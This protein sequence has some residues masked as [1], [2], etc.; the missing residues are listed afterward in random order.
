MAVSPDDDGHGSVG[1]VVDVTL[2]PR[3]LQVNLVW[4]GK[5]RGRGVIGM[6]E[7]EIGLTEGEGSLGRLGL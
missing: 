4:G 7:R 3:E 1:H 6:G 5:K 2:R